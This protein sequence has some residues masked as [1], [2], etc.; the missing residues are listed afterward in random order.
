MIVFLIFNIKIKF[1]YIYVKW[2]VGCLELYIINILWDNI[3][4]FK[5]IMVILLEFFI[6]FVI[7][8]VMELF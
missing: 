4:I 3:Y 1:E 5:K 6:G 7:C 2:W 8:C